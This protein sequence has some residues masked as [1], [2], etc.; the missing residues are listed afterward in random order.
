[1][2]GFMLNLHTWNNL[3][4]IFCL[5]WGIQYISPLVLVFFFYTEPYDTA[6]S[7]FWHTQRATSYDQFLEKLI[8]SHDNYS[9]QFSHSVVSDSLQP[10]EQQHTRLSCPS[11][12]PGACSNSCPLSQ[13]CHTISSSVIPFSSCLQSFPAS[14]SFPMSLF[15]TSGGQSMVF[16]KKI[17]SLKN[18]GWSWVGKKYDIPQAFYSFFNILTLR[19]S[20]PVR[21]ENGLS[22]VGHQ[23]MDETKA[24]YITGFHALRI[25]FWNSKARGIYP[26]LSGTS[27]NLVFL[28]QSSRFHDLT[29]SL[30][31]AFP[32]PGPRG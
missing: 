15:F 30:E 19:I 18:P 24:A 16:L 9:A 4:K 11:P 31:R 8:S 27:Y 22:L 10:H 23:K 2:T 3:H 1:M 29:S 28:M 13:W 20:F 25:T 32:N 17:I 7:L 26:A 21:S 6:N 5:Y 14:G 12:T